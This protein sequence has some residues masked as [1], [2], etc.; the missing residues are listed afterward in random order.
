MQPE[1]WRDRWQNGEIGF[2]LDRVH[3]ALGRFWAD[4][5]NGHETVLV[6]LC[7]KTL[8]MRWLANRGHKVTGVELERR[9]VEAFFREWDIDPH[10]RERTDGLIE[11]LGAGVHVATG[12]F[13]AFRPETAPNRFYDRAA[14][15]ALPQSMRADY[16][17]HLAACVAPGAQG[18]LIAFE[19]DPADMDG[20]PFP[21][22][23]TELNAQPWFAVECLDRGDAT[24]A[25]P[26][27][28]ERGAR[29]LQ[30]VI[31]RMTRFDR[32]QGTG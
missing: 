30:E 14:L 17:A 28:V 16:L 23:E 25:Y 12:D 22:T 6:P 27:L 15:V 11:L 1:F 31:Y 10:E 4:I 19:Y 18:L 32:G 2:H 21:V 20:P 29:G 9:A 5:A 13:F 26:H 8:D 7:G 24:A 3:P